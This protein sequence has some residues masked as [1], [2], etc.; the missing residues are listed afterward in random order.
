MTWVDIGGQR[1]K[2]KVKAGHRGG[3]CVHVVVGGVEVDLLVFDVV[4]IVL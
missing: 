3:D 1:S 2:V 4:M